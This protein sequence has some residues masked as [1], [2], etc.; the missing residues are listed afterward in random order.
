MKEKE[1]HTSCEL[2]RN[3]EGW[4]DLPRLNSG[5]Y[6]HSSC[7]INQNIVFVFGGFVSP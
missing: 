5:R 7:T 3:G 2:Y 1:V 4:T 6:Q